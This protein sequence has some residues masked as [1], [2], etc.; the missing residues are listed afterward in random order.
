MEVC[1]DIDD[2]LLY[3]FDRAAKA[4]NITR[5]AA[6]REAI[7]AWLSQG[8]RDAALSELFNTASSGADQG[9]TG[10]SLTHVVKY[11]NVEPR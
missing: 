9:Y 2:E 8:R 11:D 7:A 10:E 1:V 4:R 3:E 6:A 5:N